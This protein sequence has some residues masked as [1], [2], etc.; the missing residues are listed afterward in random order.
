[1]LRP[2]RQSDPL[3]VVAALGPRMLALSAEAADGSHPH[4]VP[5]EQTAEARR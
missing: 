1:M 5:P 3:T 2:S 4:N